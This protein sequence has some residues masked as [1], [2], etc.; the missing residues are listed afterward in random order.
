MFAHSAFGPR[1]FDGS[2]QDVKKI[3]GG[4]FLTEFG[5]CVPDS[6]RPEYWGTQECEWV[7]EQA[8]KHSLSW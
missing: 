4:Q 5:I 2:H 3:G 8:D 7:L 1:V 6:S